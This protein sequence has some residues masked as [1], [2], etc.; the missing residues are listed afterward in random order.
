MQI[1]PNLLIKAVVQ[2]IIP[3]VCPFASYNSYSEQPPLLTSMFPGEVVD[4]IYL[5]L[6]CPCLACPYALFLLASG[7]WG[8]VC[9]LRVNTHAGH[10]SV[11]D[12]Y[13][14]HLL[15]LGYCYIVS[16]VKY[17]YSSQTPLSLPT[18]WQISL[19][20]KEGKAM[21]IK[22]FFVRDLLGILCHVFFRSVFSALVTCLQIMSTWLGVL[23]LYLLFISSHSNLI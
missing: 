11:W 3:V 14:C 7:S 17:L 4:Y 1:I 19:F 10:L 15:V 16:C 22:F 5:T 20:V 9:V 12:V 23:R 18:T 6:L 2:C 13:S 21:H 8:C